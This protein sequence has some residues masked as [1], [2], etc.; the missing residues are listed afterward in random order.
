MSD[1]CTF[2]HITRCLK[3]T[4]SISDFRSS[5]TLTILCR[6]AA[7]QRFSSRVSVFVGGSLNAPPSIGSLDFG[8]ECHDAGSA[9]SSRNDNIIPDR[10]EVGRR[11]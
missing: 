6:R 10:E 4:I 11:L 5:S 8:R 9:F 7:S 1:L 3:E 2:S